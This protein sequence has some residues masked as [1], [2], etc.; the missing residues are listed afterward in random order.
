MHLDDQRWPC[1]APDGDRAGPRRRRTGRPRRSP[2]ARTPR[3]GC[4]I[5]NGQP[6]VEQRAVQRRAAVRAAAAGTARSSSR[7]PPRRRRAPGSRSPPR[8]RPTSSRARRA[9]AAGSGLRPT[10]RTRGLPSAMCRL[11]R[12]SPRAARTRARPKDAATELRVPAASRSRRPVSSQQRPSAPATASTSPTGTSSPLAPSRTISGTPP[13]AVETTGTPTARAST[14][15]C[16]KFSQ[17]LVRSAASRAGDD[18]E[19]LGRAAATRG[20]RSGRPP[21]ES[22]ASAL[23]PLAGR[24]RPRSRRAGPP[25]PARSRRSRRRAP[26]GAVSRPTND[27]RPGLLRH[28]HDVDVRRRVRQHRDPRPVEPPVVRD[29]GEVGAR[30]DDRAGAAERLRPRPLAAPRP[31]SSP[32]AGTPR[33]S[34]RRG[35][36][37]GPARTPGRR[38]AS[39]RAA[40]AR[41]EE[42]KLAAA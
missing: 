16:G 36:S 11:R 38:R 25:G 26:S 15:E 14:A 35:R 30:D 21:P 2:R 23:E 22:R 9:A 20:T 37:A 1:R 12:G 4:R 32:A 33:A 29:R 42:A 13:T 34:R 19:R 10:K 3:S 8:S 7:R 5:R 18:R 40:C 27:E 39:P 24:A 41:R 6:Q 17:A 31:G 28:G